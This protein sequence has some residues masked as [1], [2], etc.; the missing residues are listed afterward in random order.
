MATEG[1][2]SRAIRKWADGSPDVAR[3]FRVQA[4]MLRVKGG[5]LHCAP[6]G[7]SD[8]FGLCRHGYAIAVEVKKPGESPTTAQ[9]SFLQSVADATATAIVAHSVA[10]ASEAITNACRRHDMADRLHSTLT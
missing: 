10:E 7:T 5:F 8:L 4:G 6:E 2:I 1:D 9:V 3:L